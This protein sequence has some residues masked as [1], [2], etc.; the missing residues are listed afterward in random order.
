MLPLRSFLRPTRFSS[1]RS[2]VRPTPS[3]PF[4]QRSVYLFNPRPVS[5][6]ARIWFKPD[7]TPRSK[8]RG[9]V[10]TSIVSGLLYATWSTLLVVEALDYEH[11]LLSTL[12]H[13]QRTD[14]D[15]STVTFASFREA[16]AY[17]AEL[18]AY[19]GQ[20]DIPPEMLAAFFRDVASWEGDAALGE[21]VHGIVR[22]AAEAV[23]DI[24]TQS[25]GA[26]ATETAVLVINVVDEAMLGIIELAEDINSDETDKLLRIKRLKDQMSAKDS[27]KSYEILG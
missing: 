17:F 12:V 26:D 19:F 8:I 7:G 5:L 22:A 6:G 15:Y 3:R 4:L 9:L 21:R 25:K 20:G 13:I 14:Y 27:S 24:L 16:L 10:I 18:C 11:Y 1:L 2:A 23:H